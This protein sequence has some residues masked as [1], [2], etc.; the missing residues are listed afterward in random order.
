MR[1]DALA[2]ELCKFILRYLLL[3]ILDNKRKS[4]LSEG[5]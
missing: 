3:T 4:D 2:L 5:K 1:E